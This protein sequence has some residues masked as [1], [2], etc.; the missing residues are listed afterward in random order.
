MEEQLENSSELFIA[1]CGE[2]FGYIEFYIG[3]ARF[4]ISM[5]VAE[6]NQAEIYFIQ[7][8]KDG[9]EE[10]ENVV[11]QHFVKLTKE[12]YMTLM[13]NVYEGIE[14][15][16]DISSLVSKRIA[17]DIFSFMLMNIS[18]RSDGELDPFHLIEWENYLKY[19]IHEVM[20]GRL[21]SEYVPGYGPED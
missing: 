5:E 10:V 16:E 17:R 6:D 19:L 18:N 21:I 11:F 20:D 9:D 13:D 8:Y 7:Y 3:S 1:T 12:E 2:G 4:A 15:K 14:F